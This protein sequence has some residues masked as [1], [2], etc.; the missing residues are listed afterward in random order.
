M[1]KAKRQS[2]E[3]K[4]PSYRTGRQANLPG[5]GPGRPKGFKPVTDLRKAVIEALEN[6][7]GVEYLMALAD[8]H[9]KA[10][11]SLVAKAMP[12]ELK[13]ELRMVNDELISVMQKRRQMLAEARG[14]VIE[15]AEVVDVTDEP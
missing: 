12:Q 3:D 15:D 1:S 4:H 11:A 9:P 6:K 8:E 2:I 5:P 10:F 14:E 13:A 7:G